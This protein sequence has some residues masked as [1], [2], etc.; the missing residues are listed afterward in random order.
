MYMNTSPE[1]LKVNNE[2]GSRELLYDDF[3]SAEAPNLTKSFI[4]VNAD[5]V[6]RQSVS[7][8]EHTL[9]GLSGE[10]FK[11]P[12]KRIFGG[13]V[14]ASVMCNSKT[15]K[16]S[17]ALIIF[18]PFNDVEPKSTPAEIS[19]YSK[20]IDPDRLEIQYSQPH[21][22]NQTT[23]SLGIHDL[24][25]AEGLGM[26]VITVFGP[27]SQ[28]FYNRDEKNSFKKGDFS[29]AQSLARLALLEAQDR[30]HGPRSATRIDR[31][32]FY[33]ASL[34][35][36]NAVGAA[37]KL[38]GFEPASLTLQELIL[39]PKNLVDLAKRYTNDSVG[40]AQKE[41]DPR[42]DVIEEPL[43]RKQLDG[44]GNE[45]QYYTRILRG[46]LKTNYLRGLT[47]TDYTY[48]RIKNLA[49]TVPVTVATAANSNV[50]A[51]TQ[52]I[53]RDRTGARLIEVQ[54]TKGNKVGHLLNEH[55]A[56]SA[57]IALLGIRAA[58]AA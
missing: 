4:Q 29:P 7:T 43:M 31:V 13:K 39:G 11:V 15:A 28:R 33:G 38:D 41:E 22:W 53:L 9:D 5:Y 6:H 27:V 8:D 34:G 42:A 24:L 52:K 56:A 32:H 55:V 21:S 3:L 16:S 50:A 20:L 35:A 57:T 45:Y 47:K 19:S 40:E 54:G 18:S 14:A 49:D 26:P 23:K 58:K 36:S 37:S 46:M 1:V 51:Q 10:Q 48:P 25:E 17:E 12:D 30:I 2:P 44:S